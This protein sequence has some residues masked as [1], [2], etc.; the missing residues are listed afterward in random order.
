MAA[1]QLRVTSSLDNGNTSLEFLNEYDCMTD[2][3]MLSAGPECGVILVTLW[4]ICCLLKHF[5]GCISYGL[6]EVGGREALDK[7]FAEINGTIFTSHPGVIGITDG[8]GID[9]LKDFGVK[10]R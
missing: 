1:L 3:L 5:S 2:F 6:E 9:S 8:V 7:D 10:G 4:L